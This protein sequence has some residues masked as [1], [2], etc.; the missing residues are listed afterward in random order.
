MVDF[1]SLWSPLIAYHIILALEGVNHRLTGKVCNLLPP[2]KQSYMKTKL[3]TN[4]HL[5]LF[6]SH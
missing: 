4:V 2:Y 1:A 3:W 6:F 5:N